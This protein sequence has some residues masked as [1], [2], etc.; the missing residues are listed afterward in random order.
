[1][2]AYIE[3]DEGYAEGYGTYGSIDV[4]DENG[5]FIKGYGWTMPA[6]KWSIEFDNMEDLHNVM[7]KIH[8]GGDWSWMDD[9]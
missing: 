5:Q 1:M 4:F 9:R 6:L 7:N 3:P 8:D 2:R